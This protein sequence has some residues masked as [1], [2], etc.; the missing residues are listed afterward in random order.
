M[1][2]L[3][4]EQGDSWLGQPVCHDVNISALH[5]EC[6]VAAMRKIIALFEVCTMYAEQSTRICG[7]LPGTSAEKA[8]EGMA[9]VR[10]MQTSTAEM[11]RQLERLV[12]GLRSG[13]EA[14]QRAALGLLLRGCGREPRAGDFERYRCKEAGVAA[15]SGRRLQEV[16]DACGRVDSA[17]PAGRVEDG[18]G[19]AVERRGSPVAQQV[20]WRACAVASV[21]LLVGAGTLALLRA[22]SLMATPAMPSAVPAHGPL[23]RTAK[24]VSEAQA[25]EELPPPEPPPKDQGAGAGAPEATEPAAGDRG[26]HRLVSEAHA[27]VELPPPEPPPK[28]R[29][30][31][32]GRQLGVCGRCRSARGGRIRRGVSWW[33]CEAGGMAWHG[34]AW[35]HGMAWMG[36][37]AWHGGRR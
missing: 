16:A 34:M 13:V 5:W 37:G 11:Q 18:T 24:L 15:P 28:K 36:D 32:R 25:V 10:Q 27:A 1:N 23:L 21:W 26:A 30:L 8:V 14:E 20:T 22:A 35:R 12:V 33:G 4:T 9:V 7:T 19:R 29:A 3:W 6:W 2:L 17:E 31:P